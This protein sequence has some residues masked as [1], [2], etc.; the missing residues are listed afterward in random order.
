MG[1]SLEKIPAECESRGSAQ[2]GRSDTPGSVCVTERNA[3]CV[4]LSGRKI[5]LQEE[6]RHSRTNTFIHSDTRPGGGV[7]AE[8]GRAWSLLAPRSGACVCSRNAI[9]F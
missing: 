1:S 4:N 6:I 5:M 2:P 8:V 7:P 9:Y 3:S